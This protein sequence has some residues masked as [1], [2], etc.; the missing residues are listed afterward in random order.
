MLDREP[1]KAGEHLTHVWIHRSWPCPWLFIEKLKE[2]L[3]NLRDTAI[4]TI[5][6]GWQSMAVTST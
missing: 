4:Q 6:E 5:K 2:K 3:D 1:N